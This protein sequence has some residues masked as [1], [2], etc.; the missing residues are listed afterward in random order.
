MTTS[1]KL[2]LVQ[3]EVRQQDDGA[4]LQACARGDTAGLGVLFDRYHDDVRR[5]LSRLAGADAHQLEDLTQTTFLEVLKAARGFRGHAA[6]KTWI[7]GIAANVVRHHVRAEA[8]RRLFTSVFVREEPPAPAPVD[9]VLSR[10]RHLQDAAQ[11]VSRLPY[12]QRVAFVMC[13]VEGISGVDVATALGV[14]PGTV[15][16][17]L[18]EARKR[19]RADVDAAGGGAR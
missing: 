13:D 16:R 14:P 12:D 17:R 5:F 6:V 18:H 4:L 2:T 10:R 1:P 19:L 9:A 3:G 15:W 7:F 8:R 11:A